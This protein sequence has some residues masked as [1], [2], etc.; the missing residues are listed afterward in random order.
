M[1]HMKVH[2]RRRRRVALRCTPRERVV[3]TVDVAIPPHS[4]EDNLCPFRARIPQCMVPWVRNYLNVRGDGNCGY[5]A[6]EATLLGDQHKWRVVKQK[7]CNELCNHEELYAETMLFGIVDYYLVAL[8]YEDDQLMAPIETWMA[9]PD[10][11]LLIATAFECVVVVVGTTNQTYLPLSP[12]C[13]T[14]YG[15]SIG[16]ILRQ[17]SFLDG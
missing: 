15:P 7:M 1:R 4:S 11:G 13:R 8:S 12:V 14:R 6:I 5:R 17:Q 2:L 3:R 10:M 9:I 16:N